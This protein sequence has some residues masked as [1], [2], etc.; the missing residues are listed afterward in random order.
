MN[1]K[2]LKKAYQDEENAVRKLK[3]LF[4]HLCDMSKE[5]LL[6]YFDCTASSELV[7]IAKQLSSTVATPQNS[8]PKYYCRCI[9]RNGIPK[10]LYTTYREAERVEKYAAKERNIILKIYPCPH[11]KG[12]HLSK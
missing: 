11:V 4:P 8:L 5:A 9:D 6:A 7:S 1:L 10:L 12:W 3:S 2:Q